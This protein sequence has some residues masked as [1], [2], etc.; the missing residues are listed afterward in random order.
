VGVMQPRD[1]L[2]LHNIPLQTTVR[3]KKRDDTGEIV[4]ELRGYAK[5]EAAAGQPQQNQSST[6][7][8]KR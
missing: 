3:C 8:W 4:N 1:S 5:K 6:P 2:E 7:P